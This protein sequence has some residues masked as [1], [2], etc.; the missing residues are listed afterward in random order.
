M[1]YPKRERMKKSNF[2]CSTWDYRIMKRRYEDG[3]VLFGVYEVFYDEKG[4][5]AYWTQDP[6]GNSYDSLKELKEDLSW[7]MSA[8]GERVLDYGKQEEKAKARKSGQR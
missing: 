1:R 7:Q 3:A 5:I 2:G 6:V 4:K 8:T